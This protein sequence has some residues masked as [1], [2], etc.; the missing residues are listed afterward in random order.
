MVLVIEGR[1]V[2]ETA[3]ER[4]DL[5]AGQFLIFSSARPYVFANGGD[6]TTRFARIVVL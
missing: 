5:E 1:L 2:I 6:G 4:H 3:E